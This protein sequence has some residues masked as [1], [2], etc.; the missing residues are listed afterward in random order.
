M[1]RLAI[2]CVGVLLGACNATTKDG[3]PIVRDGTLTTFIRE[4]TSP[5]STYKS[6]QAADDRKCREYGFKPGTE[7]YGNC[8]LQIDQIRATNE[9]RDTPV[10]VRAQ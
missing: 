7:A 6:R 8:R 3:T 2:V 10:R 1:Q 9:L 5:G 4:T